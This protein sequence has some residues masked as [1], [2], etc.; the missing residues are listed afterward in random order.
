VYDKDQASELP[1]AYV[2]PRDGLGKGE[3][4]AKEIIEWL[5]AKVAH[6]KKLRG[7]VRF[8]DE[9]SLKYYRQLHE[10][11]SN[12]MLS[13][14]EVDL[15]KDFAKITQGQ[16]SGRRGWQGKGE[17]IEYEHDRNTGNKYISLYGFTMIYLFT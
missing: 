3:K 12:I 17:A 4:E 10:R 13:D 9:V 5:G 15:W 14:S 11:V 1:R 7:G 8:V 2:V 16:G 6:H